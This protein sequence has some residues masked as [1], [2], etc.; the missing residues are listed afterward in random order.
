MRKINI[1]NKKQRDAQV[2]FEGRIPKGNI[3][4]KLPDGR[5]HINVRVLKSTN[6]TDLDALVAEKGSLEILSEEIINSDLDVDVEKIGAFIQGTKKMY[7][8]S[9]GK[10]AYSVDKMEVVKS[11]E[12]KEVERRALNQVES[13]IDGDIPLCWTG[14]ML[15][16]S[17]AISMFVF[18]RKYQ[19]RHVN[20]L[21]FDFLFDIAKTLD[22]KNSM[23]LVGGGKKGNEPLI[24]SSGGVPYRGFLEGRIQGEKYCL[25]LHL[26]N[27]ELKEIIK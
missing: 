22:E 25:I 7:L 24:F 6:E 21:T 12:G 4:Q 27:L 19:L 9:E 1:S 5:S 11:P 20:G 14:K 2:G 23:M 3:H 8:D 15:P 10:I 13:N 18:S 17:K 16:K 26:S